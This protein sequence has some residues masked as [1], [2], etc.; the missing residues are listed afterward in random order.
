MNK[1]TYQ[2]EYPIYK[3]KLNTKSQKNQNGLNYNNYINDKKKLLF[4][5]KNINL[6]LNY[7]TKD[8][9]NLTEAL[10]SAKFSINDLQNKLNIL[11]NE[12]FDMKKII[13][14]LQSSN[15]N[16]N[17]KLNTLSHENYNFIN[18]KNKSKN[19]LKINIEDNNDNNNNIHIEIN[20]LK[21]YFSDL[22]Q[23]SKKNIELIDKSKNLHSLKNQ[24][25]K[26]IKKN[27][28]LKKNNSKKD[29]LTSKYFILQQKE[30]NDYLIKKIKMEINNKDLI[31]E[32]LK[33]H[34]NYLRNNLSNCYDYKKKM[35]EFFEDEKNINQN[36]INNL[37]K[38]LQK[39]NNKNEKINKNN[40]IE[41]R[42]NH[43]LIEENSLLINK[44]NNLSKNLTEIN[45]NNKK[46]IR[47]YR[48][49]LQGKNIFIFPNLPNILK[50]ENDR[51]RKLIEKYR[52]TLN[53]LFNFINE[54]NYLF[55]DPDINPEQCLY[56]IL[57]L[58]NDIK[59]LKNEILTLLEK[60]EKYVIN[61]DNFEKKKK[62][63]EMKEKL[64]NYKN[65][66]NIDLNF[67]KKR[68]MIDFD[69]ENNNN[70]RKD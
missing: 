14:T 20:K 6:N 47:A 16:L 48:T 68:E 38:L 50:I 66:N 32:D 43:K 8:N 31:I 60:K 61:N 3:K 36:K 30:N 23:K 57:L 28:L 51:L 40:N 12:N 58:I 27:L 67:D 45:I 24:E 59:Q 65:K 17:N 55:E 70:I 22:N 26:I 25:K 39:M 49:S 10:N 62:W 41:K 42:L 5:N 64:L 34:I 18:Y 33:N 46:Q 35:K 21:K 7:L 4:N 56:N 13:N 19:R 11:H 1:F 52:K 63:D 15:E 29:I 54:L 69:F 37:S 9:E 2:Y 53:V 44:I